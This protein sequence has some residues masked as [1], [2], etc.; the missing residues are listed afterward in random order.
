M[1]LHI[2]HSSVI[3]PDDMR[4]TISISKEEL[5]REILLMTDLWT[6]GLFNNET[7]ISAAFNYI[8]GGKII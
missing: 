2:P 7:K 8:E 3:I 5:I 1:I 4:K 6:E